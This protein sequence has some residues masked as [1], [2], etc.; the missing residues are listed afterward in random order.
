M[1]MVNLH[2]GAK[3]VIVIIYSRIAYFAFFQ[4]YSPVAAGEISS[5]IKVGNLLG[6]KQT[7]RLA[8]LLLQPTGHLPFKQ[9]FSE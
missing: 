3:H 1:K 4:T 8:Q 6:D 7:D 9:E 2:F 5:M